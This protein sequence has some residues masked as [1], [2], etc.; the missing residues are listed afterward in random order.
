VTVDPHRAP[1]VKLLCP[2]CNGALYVTLAAPYTPQRRQKAIH[3]AVETHRRECAKAPPEA[4]RVYQIE[5]PR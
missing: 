5:Y 2:H 3:E 1:E 4:Q